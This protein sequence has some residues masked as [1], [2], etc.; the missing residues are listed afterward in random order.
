MIF[1]R[2]PCFNLHYLKIYIKLN[3]HRK[4][5]Q[6]KLTYYPFMSE[7]KAEISLPKRLAEDVQAQVKACWFPDLNSLVVEALRQYLVTHGG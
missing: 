4:L 7:T 6:Q 3:C 2:T 5:Q 1:S